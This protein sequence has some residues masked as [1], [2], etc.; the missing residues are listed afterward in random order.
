MAHEEM[1][2][3]VLELVLDHCYLCGVTEVTHELLSDDGAGN[4]PICQECSDALG[5]E[6]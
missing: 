2:D 3:G 6:G 4:G 1:I 5:E